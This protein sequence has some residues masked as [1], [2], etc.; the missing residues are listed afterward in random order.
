MACNDTLYREAR[1]GPEE[2][3]M[4]D[5]EHPAVQ[6]TPCEMRGKR[7]VLKDGIFDTFGAGVVLRAGG[8]SGYAAITPSNRFDMTRPP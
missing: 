3:G 4:Q 1:F 5:G 7:V 6:R 2:I 8:A